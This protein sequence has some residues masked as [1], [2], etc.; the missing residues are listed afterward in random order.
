MI[1]QADHWLTG[2]QYWLLYAHNQKLRSHIDQSQPAY[3]TWNCQVGISWRSHVRMWPQRFFSLPAET[4]IEIECACDY[5]S[6]DGRSDCAAHVNSN[7]RS[8]K[9]RPAGIWKSMGFFKFGK[10]VLT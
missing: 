3:F 2:L 1:W 6:M 7:W 9:L 4:E 5:E 8:N 10:E